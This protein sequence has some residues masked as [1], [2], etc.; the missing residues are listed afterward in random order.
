MVSETLVKLLWSGSAS[1]ARHHS[2]STQWGSRRAS[3]R[4]GEGYWVWCSEEHCRTGMS[5]DVVWMAESGKLVEVDHRCILCVIICSVF[6]AFLEKLCSEK[7]KCFGVVV[8]V[9]EFC[10]GHTR[11]GVCT[12]FLGTSS[13]CPFPTFP[14]GKFSPFFVSHVY[15][16]GSLPTGT[17]RPLPIGI[18]FR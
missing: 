1:P 2:T 4:P 10:T 14:S 6:E 9:R 16:Q 18:C 3:F 17:D 8:V 15:R 12:V 13:D 7:W 11:R 5:L